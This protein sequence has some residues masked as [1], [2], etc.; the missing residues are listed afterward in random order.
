MKLVTRDTDYALRA[1][2]AIIANKNRVTS[3]RELVRRL[4]M[5]RPFLRK[6]LQQLHHGGI[7]KSY[8]GPAGGFALAREP[9]Q[10]RL[11]D[12]IAIFQGPLRLN[13]CTFKKRPCPSTPACPLR[14]ELCKI[15]RDVFLKLSRISV[16]SLLPQ[17]RK[18]RML[19]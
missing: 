14:D 19:L 3:V 9:G 17:F 8:K 12:L 18:V 15:E 6:L 4:K 16:G 10:I 11:L 2:M 1:L 7:L 13:E 5:P